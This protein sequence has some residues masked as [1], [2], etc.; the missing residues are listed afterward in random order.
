MFQLDDNFLADLGLQDMPPSQRG[1][2]LQRIY[3]TLEIRV[4]TTLSEGLSDEQ[5][6]EFSS[7]IDRDP[8]AVIAWIDAYAADFTQDP[9]YHNIGAALAEN[10]SPAGILCEY[11]ASKWLEVNS[12]DYRDLVAAEFARVSTEIRQRVVEI[13]AAFSSDAATT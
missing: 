8:R 11:A 7:I 3:E 6:S 4:G 5:L 12:P 13:R 9:A 2:F 10:E 1:P